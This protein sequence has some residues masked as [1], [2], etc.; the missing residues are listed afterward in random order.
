MEISELAAKIRNIPD[1]PKPGIQFKDITTLLSD[2]DAFHTV[3]DLLAARYQT[4]QIDAVLGIEARGFIFSSALAYRLDKGLI[5]VRKPKKLPYKTKKISYELE[6]GT[7]ILEIHED[8]I[9]PGSNILIVD[10]LLATGGTVAGVS[11]LVR[12]SGAGVVECAFVIELDFLNGRK[13]LAGIPA[14]SL[15]HF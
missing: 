12:D 14:F 10:D 1:F 11:Q 8:A 4:Q 6:Y 13:K 9:K 2:K 5:I 3:I 15:I 7:D